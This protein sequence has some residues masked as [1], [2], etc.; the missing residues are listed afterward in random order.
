VRAGCRGAGDGD[1]CGD[2]DIMIEKMGLRK[3]TDKSV[4]VCRVKARDGQ[5]C[6][7]TCINT[8]SSFL[9]TNSSISCAV[10]STI[11]LAILFEVSLPWKRMWPHLLDAILLASTFFLVLERD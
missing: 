6:R 11:M 7:V 1:G 3:R 8:K 2:M 9:S 4:A 10:T 5:Q